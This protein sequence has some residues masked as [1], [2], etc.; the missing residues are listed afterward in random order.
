MSD[1][2]QRLVQQSDLRLQ[3]T[4]PAM[5]APSAAAPSAG[6]NV[7]AASSDDLVEIH[8]EQVTEAP[9]RREESIAPASSTMMPARVE[10]VEAIGP[11]PAQTSAHLAS[12]TPLNPNPPQAATE[13][14]VTNVPT[15]PDT[16]PQPT[17]SGETSES[18]VLERTAAPVP[19]PAKPIAQP[20]QAEVM[21]AVMKW[22]AAG[23]ALPGPA[24][25]KRVAPAS[26]K[27]LTPPPEP[28]ATPALPASPPPAREKIPERVIKLVEA[29]VMPAREATPTVAARPITSVP[30]RASA[31]AAEAP[32]RVSIG[33]IQVNV[34][35]PAPA[36]KPQ[37]PA[38][39]AEPNRPASR[40]GRSSTTSQLRRHYIIPH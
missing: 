36:A 25:E 32:V 16:R 14:L 30:I 2:F 27:T 5:R 19:A 39:T 8:E 38:R 24:E 7:T 18:I 26:P 21:Q 6:P 20:S 23:S 29:H 15:S 34:A 40:I 37:R 31:A 9:P 3:A 17:P 11:A 22:I 4:P 35:A 10:T 13:S 12:V 33:S 28:V 1:Y